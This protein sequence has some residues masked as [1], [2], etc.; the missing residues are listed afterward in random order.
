MVDNYL[1]MT[2]YATSR[3]PIYARLFLDERGG[4]DTSN[5]LGDWPVNEEFTV[6]LPDVPGTRR[7][8]I[9]VEYRDGGDLLAEEQ[10]D[11]LWIEVTIPEEPEVPQCEQE[12][13]PETEFYQWDEESCQWVCV[14]PE[15]QDI[16]GTYGY[17]WD[18]EA[19][20]YVE[21]PPPPAPTCEDLLEGVTEGNYPKQGNPEA[22]CSY[23]G[24]FEVVEKE[25]SWPWDLKDGDFYLCKAGTT[26]DLRFDKF[27][28]LGFK[29]P[30]GK[31]RSHI[32]VCACPAN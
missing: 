13:E 30:N 26:M 19:C 15:R 28:R 9:D 10:A 18:Q 7:I 17:E 4:P 20:D 16:F 27:S 8:V 1:T 2:V 14:K 6:M 24:P 3:C 32:T 29:C 22:E 31:N 23:F 11:G 5:F 21:I 12:G 25:E